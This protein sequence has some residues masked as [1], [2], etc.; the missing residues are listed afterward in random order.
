MKDHLISLYRFLFARP[1]LYALN[2]H[3]YKLA[4][5]G[6]GVLN[7]EG[8]VVTGE[9]WLQSQFA[10]HL[11]PKTIID[12]GAN[13][14][15]YGAE[16]FPEAKIY[17]CEPHPVTFS[18]LE[19]IHSEDVKNGHITL[20]NIALSD[21]A[22]KMSLYDF[23]DDAE[24]KHTQPTSALASLSKEVIEGLHKQ[25]AKSYKVEVKTID[26]VI[27]EHKLREV[28][29]LKIDTEGHEHHV[30]LG[31]KQALQRQRIKVIQFEFNEM[32]VTTRSF[33]SDFM[34]LLPD[35]MFYRLLPRGVVALGPY[36]PLTHELFGFQNIICVRNDVVS[37]LP[38][39]THN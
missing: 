13:L 16:V 9:T 25:K 12:V 2:L 24:L 37:Q 6:L 30:L 8:P 17:A 20:L 22:A 3:L 5:R 10:Q 29:I 21:T 32:N 18:R 34:Q 36:R 14:D 26:Q 19:K 31:A 23:A 33:L 7:A 15:V 28:D 27:K 1:S 11:R 4:L 35:Y 38:F 39:L